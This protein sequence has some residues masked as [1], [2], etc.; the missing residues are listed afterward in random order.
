MN[1]NKMLIGISGAPHCG[2]DSICNYLMPQL[3]LVRFGPSVQ[4]KR[5]TAAMFDIPEE[6][7]YDEKMKEVV[8]DYWGI[9]Y[10]NMAQLVG[11]ECSRDILGDD[12]WLRHVE[13]Q[14]AKT[15]HRGFILPDIRYAN[16]VHW[17]KNHGGTV[18]FVYRKNRPLASNESH[19]AEQ[20]VDQNLADYIIQND[21]TL[22]G[23]YDKLDAIV[24]MFK[25]QF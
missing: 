9:T 7:L 5:A 10:R 14:L 19:P 22:E 21:S 16:E 13:K 23:L 6:Y 4:V 18:I 12:F 3:D 8:D 25:Q 1:K 2:K 24:D 11:K 15:T 20:G 17:V